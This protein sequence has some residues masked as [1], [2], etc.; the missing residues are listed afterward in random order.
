MRVE[1]GRFEWLSVK[2]IVKFV[3]IN[4]PCVEREYH[5]VIECASYVGLRIIFFNYLFN[6][7]PNFINLEEAEKWG[8][9]MNNMNA[10]SLY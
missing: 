7:Y 8:I 3:N 10:I 5:F 2:I 1:T 4:P 6:Y 9:I